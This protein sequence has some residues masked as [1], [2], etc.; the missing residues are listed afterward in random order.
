MKRS[1]DDLT[2]KFTISKTRVC[3]SITNLDELITLS[4]HVKTGIQYLHV[5]CEK[6][7]SIN[8]GIK[9]L[10]SMVGF[11]NVK[12]TVFNIIIYYLQDLNVHDDEYLHTLITGPPGTGKTTLSEILGEIYCHLGIL[13]SGIVH[14][15]KRCDLIGKWCGHT[16][17]KVNEAVEK[18]RGGVLLIDEGYALGGTEEHA[19]T[20]SNECVNALNQCLSE[21]KKDFVCIMAG[22]KDRMEK[23]LFSMNEGLERRFA[24]TFDTTGVPCDLSLVFKN[25]ANKCHWDVADDAIPNGFFKKND[26]YF[27]FGGGSTEI[28]FTKC[29][30][31]YSRRLFGTKPTDDSPMIIRED[32]IAG[33]N[34]YKKHIIIQ[35]NTV[36][37][38]YM[39]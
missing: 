15:V 9:R 8:S 23:C 3:P 35:P 39:M 20:F 30:M 6:L 25:Q 1:P 32:I 4:D 10:N 19:D 11:Q 5:D 24:W 38:S 7:K 28:L 22:Y 17:I 16:A 33:F 21:Q 34:E 29:K 36:I 18:A 37:L 14:K 12:E 2:L 31:M 13:S 26:K 27:T